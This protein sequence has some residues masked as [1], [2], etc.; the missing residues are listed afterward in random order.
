[1]VGTLALTLHNVALA[2]AWSL[3]TVAFMAVLSLI[4]ALTAQEDC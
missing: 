3:G 2:L 1:M 4:L